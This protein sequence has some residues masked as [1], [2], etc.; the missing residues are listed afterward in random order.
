[1]AGNQSILEDEIAV[2]QIHIDRVYERLAE[3]ERQAR[4]LLAEGHRRGTVGNVGAL[5]ERDAMV[6][7]AARRMQSLGREHEGLVFGRLDL[8]DGQVRYVGRLGVR[9]ADYEPLVLDWRAPAA[10]PFY[11]ATAEQPLGVVRRRVIRCLGQRV[12]GL[13]DDLLDPDA[14]PDGMRVVG[15]GALLAA[16]NRTRTGRMHDIVATIQRE[17]DRA[18]RAPAGGVTTITGGPGTGK[19]VVA[20]HRAAYLLYADRRRF[21]G[22]GVLIVGPSAVFMR[23]IERVLP[24]LGES[25]ASLRAVGEVVDGVTATLR[26]EPADAAVKGSLRMRRVLSQAVRVVPVGA[27]E[28]LRLTY[29]GQV[30]TLAARDLAAV[31]RAVLTRGAVHNRVRGRARERL[32]GALWQRLAPAG[33]PPGP[34]PPE[35]AEHIADRNEFADFLDAWWPLLTPAAVLRGLADRGRLARCSSGV[36]AAGEVDRLAASWARPG[37]SGQDVALLDELRELLGRPPKPPAEP[38]LYELTGVAELSTVAERELA[39]PERAAREEDYERYAHLIVDEAQ[40]LSPMQWRMLGRRGQLASWTVVGDAAQSMWPDA[41]EAAQAREAALGRK[42][43]HEF[44]LSTNYRNP[45]EIFE[46]AARVVRRA[47]PDADLPLAVRRTGYPPRL[48]TVPAADLPAAVAA[49]VSAVLA[50]VEGAVGVVTSQRGRHRVAGW[51]DSAAAD[52]VAADRLP[53]DRV[54][55]DRV[56]PD[57]VASDRVAPDRVAAYGAP[58]R[59]A[60]VDAVEVKG[61]EYDAVVVVEP[62]DLVAE[63]ARG[64]RALY[65]ALTRAT[66]RL[67]VVGSDDSWLAA[68]R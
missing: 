54:A 66:Q 10:G 18:I 53:S 68:V 43:R 67:A 62:A 20:L 35:F 11:R 31:R 34:V 59:V 7:Q 26:D 15:D 48:D 5:V 64:V 25:S 32:I 12:V 19:T 24:S 30:L 9:D 6:Y 41:A 8:A 50:E 57:R 45:A 52:R 27:P 39:P 46:L 63:S 14:V 28:R 4:L 23:Y 21:E 60:V 2:E 65:V 58:D 51:L 55:P 44:R 16:V 33:E 47:V 36:L 1:V 13:E 42:A 38:S 37:L 56:A 61:L 17:Q 22:G 40:D 29:R 3:A 49:A